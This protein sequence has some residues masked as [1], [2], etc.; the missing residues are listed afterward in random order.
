MA[1]GV[2][3]TASGFRATK[4]DGD[5]REYVDKP[6]NHIFHE[7]RSACYIESGVTLRNIIENVGRIPELAMLIG[8]YSWC[9]VDAFVSEIRK[10]T[11]KPSDLKRIE[12]NALLEIEQPYN[13]ELPDI[14]I[15]LDVYGRDDSDTRW[16]IELTPVNELA[17]LPVVLNRTIAIHDWRNWEL[18]PD[19][20]LKVDE[21]Q[22]CFTLLEVLS[23]IFFEIS[24]HGSP[25]ERDVFA[26][27]LKQTVEDIES[28]KAKTI[29]WEPEKET[30]Q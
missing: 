8:Q 27:D 21:G 16:A 19:K 28:G 23:Q 25:H 10:P 18:R 14:H 6:I 1:E 5:V 7:L 30:I 20:N 15:G 26:S 9:D 11:P 22:Y 3:I 4:W 17:E 12:I 29:P 24:F 2:F 13:G